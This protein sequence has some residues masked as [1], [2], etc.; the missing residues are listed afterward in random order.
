MIIFKSISVQEREL[1]QSFTLNNRLCSCDY[2]FANIFSWSFRFGTQY[3]IVDG[4]L[5]LRFYY[6]DCPAY[7]IPVPGPQ[8]GS[9]TIGLQ[10]LCTGVDTLPGDDETEVERALVEVIR[11]LINQSASVGCPFRMLGLTQRI[12]GLMEMEFPDMFVYRMPIQ[13]VRSYAED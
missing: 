6:G 12:K 13:D 11:K 5:V 8:F 3:A 10:C 4:F 1:I 9:R 2:S 7:M